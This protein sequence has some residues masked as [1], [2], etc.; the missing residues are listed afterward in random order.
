MPKTR[1]TLTIQ[2]VFKSASLFKATTAAQILYMDE[3]GEI[4]YL[5]TRNSK[6]TGEQLAREGFTQGVRATNAEAVFTRLKNH[7]ETDNHDDFETY[8]ARNF[9]YPDVVNTETTETDGV[10]EVME[11][12]YVRPNVEALFLEN[13]ARFKELV[14]LLL[15]KNNAQFIETFNLSLSGTL[16]PPEAVLGWDSKEIN[17]QIGALREYS[18]HTKNRQKKSAIEHLMTNLDEIEAARNES[19]REDPNKAGLRNLHAKV[20]ILCELQKADK[21]LSEHKG[22]KR[23][24]TNVIA[25]LFTLGIAQLIKWRVTG[26]P[27]LFNETTSQEKSTNI[28]DAVIGQEL[29]KTLKK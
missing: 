14:D 2:Q 5:D 9:Y 12:Y 26:K 17:A 22:W 11:T 28:A 19:K 21:A 6:T 23:V 20:A 7:I 4:K 8:L 25:A 15:Q 1:Y 13:T 24:I 16:L 10:H 18:K 27:L 3:H 29:R